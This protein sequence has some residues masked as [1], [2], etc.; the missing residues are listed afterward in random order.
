LILRDLVGRIKREREKP[1]YLC[2]VKG[3]KIRDAPHLPQ[4][5]LQNRCT[6]VSA[7]ATI[8]SNS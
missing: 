2:Y 1:P 8:V 7:V 5:L 6:L 3:K 4:S